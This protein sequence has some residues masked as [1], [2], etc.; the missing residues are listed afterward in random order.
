[1]TLVLFAT[2]I[3]LNCLWYSLQLSF[4]HVF[5]ILTY[6]YMTQTG[7]VQHKDTIRRNENVA[8]YD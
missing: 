7:A 2:F 8:A 5:P 4:F 3:A 1:M 6:I